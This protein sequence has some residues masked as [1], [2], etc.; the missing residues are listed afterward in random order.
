MEGEG[1][2]GGGSPSSR[3]QRDPHARTRRRRRV[4]SR[5]SGA[6]GGRNPRLTLVVVEK[7]IRGSAH[8]L[9]TI[10]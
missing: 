3:R 10:V 8:R 6:R 5:G 7:E 4:C 2:G 9:A 1:G